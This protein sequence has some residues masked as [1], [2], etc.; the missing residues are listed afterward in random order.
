MPSALIAPPPHRRTHQARPPPPVSRLLQ[1]L[2]PGGLLVAPE[3]CR[4][5]GCAQTPE[6]A[7]LGWGPA[8]GML[9]PPVLVTPDDGLESPKEL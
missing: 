9:P 1:R 5:S 8:F 3:E 7:A 6:P 4:I 2:R